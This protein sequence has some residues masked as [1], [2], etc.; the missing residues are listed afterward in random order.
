MS[1]RLHLVKVQAEARFKHTEQVVEASPPQSVPVSQHHYIPIPE[2]FIETIEELE[3]Q[4][5]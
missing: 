5:Q 4:E 3:D 2:D 1:N